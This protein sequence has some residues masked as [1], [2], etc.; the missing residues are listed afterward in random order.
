M[1]TP[2]CSRCG[3]RIEKCGVAITRAI[4]GRAEDLTEKERKR[5]KLPASGLIIIESRNSKSKLRTK[6][7][8]IDKLGG[9][10]AYLR[11]LGKFKEIEIP[12]E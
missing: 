4:L 6:I 3:K 8:P 7:I 5:F 11:S 2:K 9:I 1:P 12:N 10:S